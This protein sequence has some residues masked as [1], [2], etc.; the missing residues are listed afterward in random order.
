MEN[1]IMIT[2]DSLRWDH[3]SYFNPESP[4]STPNIDSLAEDGMAFH[5]AISNGPYTVLSAPTLL[6][7]E[8]QPAIT[9]ETPTL[10]E[11][12][13]K[14]GYETAAFCTN[15]QLLG[16]HLAPMDLTRGFETFDTL[17]DTVREKSE[18]QLERAAH[19]VGRKAKGVFGEES[20]TYRAISTLMS[21]LPLPIARPTPSAKTVN[22]RALR[23]LDQSI[24]DGDPYFLWL[25]HLDTHEPWLPPHDDS[26]NSPGSVFEQLRTHGINRKYRYFKSSL[27]EAELGKLEQLYTE[28][29]EYWDAQI[30]AFI[31]EL[32]QR[33]K[34]PTIIIT[35]DHGEMLGEKGEFGHPPAPWE[36][37]LRVP[38]VISGP[39]LKACDSEKVVQNM[40]VVN[41][42]LDI[43][44]ATGGET[45]RGRSLVSEKEP[46]NPNKG[47]VVS[48][49]ND[50]PLAFA[51][52]TEEWKY[53]ERGE[54]SS[55]YDLTSSEPE[56]EGVYKEYPKIAAELA[57]DARDILEPIQ[58]K[59]RES[60]NAET[61]TK[62]EKRL[63]SLG[64]FSE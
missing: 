49:L 46:R 39:E 43:T 25:F 8:Y 50:D 27:T 11:R 28:S 48:I 2:A 17:L 44:N 60:G 47:G 21:Y 10:A 14:A 31:E 35:S 41:T 24:N 33:G 40:D 55:L 3:I 63:R 54:E 52:R 7:G 61:D 53:V 15:I 34:N 12:L 32:N 56:A 57:T 18:F 26:S 6:T 23:W 64:Y 36:Q 1:V 13:T 29:I 38:L 4:A 59:P 16:A 37:L 22:E 9:A 42:I 19:T 20:Q 62:I 30:G 5:T 58:I 51:Y 45:F